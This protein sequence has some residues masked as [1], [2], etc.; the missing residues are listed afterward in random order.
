MSKKQYKGIAIGILCV[1]VVGVVLSVM[2]TQKKEKEVSKIQKIPSLMYAKTAVNTIRDTTDNSFEKLYFGSDGGFQ[3]NILNQR[4]NSYQDVTGSPK[5]TIL[6][7]SDALYDSVVF[8]DKSNVYQDSQLRKQEMALANQVLS[9][10]ERNAVLQSAKKGGEIIEG[11]SYVYEEADL[12]G[13]LFFAP[14][15]SIMNT[16][17]YGLSERHSRQERDYFWLS[18]KRQGTSKEAGYISKCGVFATLSINTPIALRATTNIDIG[19]V[20]FVQTVNGKE[21]GKDG[22][23]PIVQ[24]QAVDGYCLTV[25]DDSQTVTI[26]KSVYSNNELNIAYQTTGEGNRLSA[27]VVDEE[28]T[29]ILYYGQVQDIS[30]VKNGQVCIDIPKEVD[31]QKQHLYLFSEQYHGGTKTDF[32][33]GLVEIVI[34]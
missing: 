15:A 27:I 6:M 7:I 17:K 30:T 2:P 22:L 11:G 26:D 33:S 25:K 8:D 34:E 16:P 13:D 20:G 23:Q 24:K 1:V 21:N 4:E 31:L 14:T 10:K 5:D 9:S 19:K 32:C 12:V 29:N 28:N 3:W 18:S